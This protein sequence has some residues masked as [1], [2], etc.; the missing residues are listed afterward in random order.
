MG[1]DNNVFKIFLCLASPDLPAAFG[2]FSIH[3][4]LI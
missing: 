1:T 4:L 2:V 3:A